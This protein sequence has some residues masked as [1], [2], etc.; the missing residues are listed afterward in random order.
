MQCPSLTNLWKLLLHINQLLGSVPDAMSSFLRLRELCLDG[1]KLKGS[2]PRGLFHLQNLVLLS[3][4]S[5]ELSGTIDMTE[6]PNTGQLF[7]LSIRANALTGT[8][9]A[10]RR[11]SYIH[12]LSCSGNMLEGTLPATL[13]T[14]HLRILDASGKGGQSRGLLGLLP[15][16][17][18][19]AVAL[20]SKT[21][22]S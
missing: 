22:R 17:A 19:Q 18:S 6:S 3:M 15:P 5:N 4:C 20:V 21:L 16:E 14:S 2:I 1:N 9:P 13:M 7:S 8:L 11:S 10:C 12:S